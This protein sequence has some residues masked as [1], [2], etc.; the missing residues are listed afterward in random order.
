M[1]FN[2]EKEQ[3]IRETDYKKESKKKKVEADAEQL[4][5]KIIL[6]FAGMIV[7]CVTIFSIL[8]YKRYRITQKQKIVIES[9]KHLVE[10]KQKEILD[11]IYYAK[12]IQDSL[13]ATERYIEK[14]ITRLKDKV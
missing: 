11:S 6:T 8:L 9:Q 5:Q 14:T 7:I 4:R 2:F 1:K 12:R 10:E 13:L 3:A